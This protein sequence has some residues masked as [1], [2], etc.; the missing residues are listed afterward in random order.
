[1][2]CSIKYTTLFVFCL[3]I[4]AILTIQVQAYETSGY[5]SITGDQN[6]TATNSINKFIVPAGQSWSGGINV[7]NGVNL[8][9]IIEGS[10]TLGWLSINKNATL[11]VIIG[12]AGT[13]NFQTLTNVSN[14]HF[15]IEN[16]SGNLA[17]SEVNNGILKN[18][19][20]IVSTSGL[21]INS[22]TSIENN[23]SITV[24]GALGINSTSSL[25]NK[26]T[27]TINGD[28]N[29]NS[30]STFQNYCKI[31]VTGNV[32]INSNNAAIMR[33]GSFLKVN[34]TCFFYDDITLEANSFIK[35]KN[36]THWNAQI[37]GPASGNALI[38][39]F[40]ALEGNKYSTYASK[41]IYLV[42]GYGTQYGTTTP[43]AFSIASSDCN[44]G[45]SLIADSDGDSIPDDEDEFPDD[46][47]R[48]FTANYLGETSWKTLMFE[49]L[50]PNK[51]DYDFNDLVIKYKFTFHL[52][53]QSEYVGLESQFQVAACG[54]E[55]PNGFGFQL[56][57]PNASVTN[58]TGYVHTGSSIVLN[59]NKTEQGAST[60]AV[61]IVYDNINASLGKM[62][63]VLKSG[64][65]KTVDPITVYVS[66]NKLAP[67][68]SFTI[69]PF[70]YVNQIRGREVHLMN[71]PP[72]SKAD[73]SLFG[74]GD[75][76]STSGM[77][78]RSSEG[79]PWAL[80]VPTDVSH[81]LERIDFCVGY[82]EFKSWAESGGALYDTWYVDGIY[83]PALY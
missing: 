20:G 50:W 72:T 61:I 9:L 2:K 79:L 62:F 40:G 78:Y 77:F 1:M 75:D 68:T 16:Y 29:S 73:A 37:S 55:Y 10:A 33:S 69:N 14:D 58:V 17:V 15:T 24:T 30:R 82:P 52:N 45:F 46:A 80:N 13:I 34:G 22:G 81:V 48:A 8:S 71:T 31:T 19:G 64:T 59:A 23:G 65:T 42:D 3:A 21:G 44:E 54:A 53:A 6:V 83:S 60:E 28:L 11:H 5:T 25:I 32:S 47:E 56:N 4:L 36:I 12:S 35:T 27:I 70:I 51:G 67:S 26:G 57:I 39:Y 18:Y 49:D 38:Q 41:N 63:N 43:V 76:R 7:N 74:T 66:L